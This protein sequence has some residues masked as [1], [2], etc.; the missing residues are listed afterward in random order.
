MIEY[1]IQ[2]SLKSSFVTPTKILM[3]LPSYLARK[4][5]QKLIRPVKIANIEASILAGINLAKRTFPESS[6]IAL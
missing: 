1:R 4:K 6:L 5:L 3:K 2:R